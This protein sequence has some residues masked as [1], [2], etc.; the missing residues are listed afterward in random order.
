MVKKY[1]ELYL[2]ARRELW[3]TEGENSSFVAREL[4]C[5]ASGKTA[6]QMI[7]DRD[8][9]ASAEVV[10]L[11]ESFV[12]R[13][14]KGEPMPYILGQWDFYDMTLTVTRDVLIP[15]DD[16]MAVTELAIK[17][18]LFLDQNPRILDLCT[19]SGCIGLAI[20]KRVK[21]ARVTLAD[22]SQAALRVARRNSIDL[23]LNARVSCIVLDAKQPAQEFIG[24]F[25]LIVANP[26]YVTSEEMLTLDRS[27]RDFEPH[28][29]LHG[30]EDG[31]DFYRAIIDNYTSALLP[32]GCFCFEIGKGQEDAVC[33]LLESAGFEI[34]ELRRDSAEIIR[35]ILAQK[36]EEV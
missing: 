9:Y 7:A 23:K 36:R 5:A 17:K 1:A 35:A 28:L 12:E 33:A 18:A 13:Y 34:L 14:L 32:K 25:H 31:L 26:P 29:A 3:A 21:D 19:G 20:A 6:E 22:I 4:V 15:R 11:T 30:G 8:K 16:T 2:D 27:V 10:A 24:K